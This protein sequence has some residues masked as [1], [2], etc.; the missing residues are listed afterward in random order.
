[1]EPLRENA[2]ELVR[3]GE[4]ERA[5]RLLREA[6]FDVRRGAREVGGT[7]ALGLGH[8]AWE[9]GLWSEAVDWARHVLAQDEDPDRVVQAHT[10]VIASL[11]EAQRFAEGLQAIRGAGD[12]P[13]GAGADALL[14]FHLNS[15]LV[16]AK[17]GRGEEALDRYALA[18]ES[19]DGSSPELRA[20]LELNRGTALNELGRNEEAVAAYERA[21]ALGPGEHRASAELNLGNALRELERYHEAERHYAA[22]FQAADDAAGLRGAVLSNH[23]RSLV[24]RGRTREA[25]A[26]FQ[27]AIALRREAGDAAGEAITSEELAKLLAAEADYQGAYEW[28]RIAIDLRRSTGQ[29]D[30]DDLFRLAS[31]MADILEVLRSR[32]DGAGHL[33]VD[34]MR[35]T[36]PGQWPE[37][38]EDATPAALGHAVRRLAD[39]LEAGGA[40]PGR[41]VEDR[42]MLR[43]LERQRAA[44]HQPAF[45]EHEEHMRRVGGILNTALDLLRHPHWIERKR[46]YQRLDGLLESAEAADVL[47]MMEDRATELEVEAAQLAALRELAA[48]CRA[49]GVDRAFA[50]LPELHP[51]ELLNRILMVGTWR[52]T[53]QIVQAHPQLLDDET[54]D[55]LQQARDVAPEGERERVEQHIAVLRRCRVVGVERAFAEAPAAGDEPLGLKATFTTTKLG[56]DVD[57]DPVAALRALASDSG[58][59]AALRREVLISLGDGVL[60]R[61]EGDRATVL[62]EALEAYADADDVPGAA[63]QHQTARIAL[64]A[65][66]ALLELAAL[67][68]HEEMALVA[69]VDTY[70]RALDA[71]PVTAAPDRARAAA[72]G[73]HD[74]VA[75]RLDTSP[76]YSEIVYLRQL[77]VRACR[78]AMAATDELVRSGEV[79]D[80]AEERVGTLWAY[81]GAVEELCALGQYAA[82]LATAEHGRARGFLAEIARM[83]RLPV[84]VPAALA[85]REAHARETVRAARA[86]E[87]AS[88]LRAAEAALQG[89]HAELARI[90][91]ELGRLRAGEPP[92]AE[93]LT[94]FMSAQ[95]P[96]LVVLAWYTTPE[97]TYAF[98]LQGGT[99]TVRGAR[100]ALDERRL[101]EFVALAAEDVWRRPAAPDQP[102]SPA[103]RELADAL[104]PAAWRELV[105]GAEEIV[106]V[107]HGLLGDLPLHALPLR[108]L[109]GRS[110]LEHAPVVYLP[111]MALAHRLRSRAG[112]GDVALVLAHA[113][114][115][116]DAGPSDFEREAQAIAQT[117]GTEH[118]YVGPRA[119]Q[120]RLTELAPR[121]A[122]VHIAAHGVYEAADPLGS[123]VLLSDGTWEGTDPLSARE[124]LRLPPLPGAV[125]VLS[126]CETNRRGTDPTGEGEGLVRALFVAGARAVVAGQWRVDSPTTRLLM[127]RFHAQLHDSGDVPAA[128]RAAALSL[129]ASPQTAHPYYWAPF[130]PAA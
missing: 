114:L 18:D 130:V 72:A 36:V 102:L 15:A 121:T 124:V 52:E 2:L 12:P 55:V 1:M 90:A 79:D 19:A 25:K 58:V 51:R 71:S 29:P 76:P 46:M 40:S 20:A 26:M 33:L 123:K 61:S 31:S 28:A 67:E 98:V 93:E 47:R 9:L 112:A 6:L 54:L 60:E 48:A 42:W 95:P 27:D 45:A 89:V 22:A 92:A 113:G 30:D 70:Q 17:M 39:E 63:M 32:P 53:L 101:G 86:A 56:V 108:W 83:E 125:V 82:A 126:G 77:R 68:P 88:A 87:D 57:D 109:D 105:A 96:G 119:R 66:A 5:A 35:A 80:P 38:S 23:A 49:N 44:G 115:P 24:A 21:L 116:E 11:F 69:A 7:D 81:D 129:K 3:R 34:R 103:W 122:L 14:R 64:R 73:F 10:V 128:L 120:A 8:A 110:L 37:L 118:V 13:P 111:G 78:A 97:A 74:A 75:A 107:P 117:V 62:R 100:L 41:R 59:D 84:S 4:H 106:L 94:A 65:G 50:E 104:V 16:L 99:A 91:P 85:E 43:F 127:E